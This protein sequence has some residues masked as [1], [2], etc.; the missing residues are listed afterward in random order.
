MKSKVLKKKLRGDG[1]FVAVLLIIAVVCVVGTYYGG[2]MEGWFQ[3]GIG[4]FE[5]N[6]SGIFDNISSTD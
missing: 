5:T 1:H 4:T 3:N 6:T 2:E